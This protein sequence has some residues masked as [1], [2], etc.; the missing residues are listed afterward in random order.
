MAKDESGLRSAKY[1]RDKAEEARAMASQLHHPAARAVMADIA[2][3]YERMA[4]RAAKRDAAE[5]AGTNTGTN[6]GAKRQTG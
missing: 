4:E 5:A 2:L 3:K 6:T 1:W